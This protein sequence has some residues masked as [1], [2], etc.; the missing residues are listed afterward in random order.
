MDLSELLEVAEAQRAKRK[1]IRVH[2][3]TSTG[4]RAASSVEVLS[5]LQGAVADQGLGD[6]IDVVGVGC[7]GFCGRG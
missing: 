5:N 1:S 4:C 3:C 7:M 2:C 6:R